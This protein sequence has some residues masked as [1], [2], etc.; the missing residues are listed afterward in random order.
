[1]D[2]I[3]HYVTHQFEL[4][5]SMQMQDVIKMCYQAAFGAEHLLEDT[6]RARRYF[7]KEFE[8]VP[9]TDEALFE[10]IGPRVSRA[11]FGAWKREGFPP[12]ELF[13]LFAES[14][15]E[16]KKDTACFLAYLDQAGEV[17]PFS[18]DGWLKFVEDYKEGGIRPIHHSD[19]YREKEKPA[20]RVVSG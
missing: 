4:H 12:E 19:V 16:I 5:P 13:R 14:S 17:V 1:M 9:E 2:D 7:Y 18:G 10:L 3:R 6:E 11:N 8:S 15:R 20:Y